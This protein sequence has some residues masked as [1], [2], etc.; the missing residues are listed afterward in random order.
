MQL[1]LGNIWCL[2][3]YYF[4]QRQVYNEG[5]VGDDDGQVGDGDGQ[6]GDDDGQVDDDDGQVDDDGQGGD[7]LN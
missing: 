1:C 6:G 4:L 7:I 5:Q 3:Q 2:I